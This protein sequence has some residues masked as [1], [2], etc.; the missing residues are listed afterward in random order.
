MRQSR[1]LPGST[2]EKIRIHSEVYTPDCVIVLDPVLYKTVPSRPGLKK[3][4]SDTLK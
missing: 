1:P 3:G 4:G 2:E